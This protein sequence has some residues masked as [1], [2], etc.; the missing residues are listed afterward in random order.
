MALFTDCAVTSIEDLRG[1]DTQLL[2][3]ATVE[4]IDVTRKLALA[5]EELSIEVTGLLGRLEQA[6]QLSAPPTV[7]QVVMTPPLK[8]WHVFR[9]LEMVYGDAY[10]SQLNDRYGGKRDEYHGRVKWAYNQLILS[11]LGI[12]TDPLKQAATPV[13]RAS[14][15]GLTDGVYYV[16]VAWTNTASEEGASSA[17]A[18]IQ[19]SG[20]SFAVETSAPSNVTGWNVYSGTSLATMTVQN[21]QILAPGQ[22]WVQPDTL[23]T[24]GRRAGS[25]QGPNYWV[26]VPRTIQRG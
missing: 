19:V 3:V 5:H 6:G 24:T 2:N 16:A 4:G 11:G 13:V 25:G 17:P 7:E 1:H 9:T 10:N 8:L 22:T 20:S 26:P 12:A 21:V 23:S 18:M 15:G 14:A